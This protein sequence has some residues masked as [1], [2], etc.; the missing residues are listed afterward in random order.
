MLAK[1]IIRGFPPEKS[2][3]Y[4]FEQA[5][6]K[7][8][9]EFIICVD[10]DD[11]HVY[12]TSDPDKLAN[13]FGANL[14][15]PQY[16]TPVFFERK[17]LQKYYNEPSKYVVD[18]GHLFCGNTWSLRM[19]NSHD[20]YVIAFLGDL[21]R[22]LPSKEQA[23]WKLH[24]VPPDGHVSDTYIK[25]SFLG[26]FTEPE[27]RAILFTD[28]YER[29]CDRWQKQFSWPLFLQLLPE[30]AHHFNTL[31]RPTTPEL[32]ELDEIVLSL[33]KLLVDS[34]NVKDLRRNIHDFNSTDSNGNAKPGISVLAEYLSAQ[35]YDDSA[36]YIDYLRRV[37]SLRSSG[38]A[39]RKGKK[40]EKAAEFFSLDS[41]STV[42]VADGILN[43]LTEFLDSL[44]ETLLPG[45]FRLTPRYQLD[46]EPAIP[47][48]TV[49]EN[50]RGVTP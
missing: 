16:V 46:R 7:Q 4:P 35:G 21:G 39:H 28:A 44:R 27:D 49:F 25:R 13:H 50:C 26:E 41:K 11:R 40:Y 33:T 48:P 18:D 6:R 17:V 1:K 10:E 31:R 43:T 14:D 19:D 34:I 47:R 37:Q 15:A 5:A 32:A 30:D 23:H 45:R 20:S 36:N 22:D 38:A 24:N 9:E 2:G 8:Y 12:Y 42:Q 3:L 29:L